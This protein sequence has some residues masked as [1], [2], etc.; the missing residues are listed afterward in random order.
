MHGSGELFK[1]LRECY[2]MLTRHHNNPWVDTIIVLTSFYIPTLYNDPINAITE[3]IFSHGLRLSFAVIRYIV[4][5]TV[6]HNI[7]WDTTIFTSAREKWFLCV[8]VNL[9]QV[10]NMRICKIFVVIPA[11]HEP[12]L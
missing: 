5:A 11:E 2:L 9:L 4:H 10:V 1:R 8:D 7:K 12:D 3:T 6:D